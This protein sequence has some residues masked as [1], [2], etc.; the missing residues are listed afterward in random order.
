MLIRALMQTC[1]SNSC[2]IWRQ[3]N[4]PA[5]WAFSSLLHRPRSPLGV[6]SSRVRVMQTP[7]LPVYGRSPPVRLLVQPAPQLQTAGNLRG[8]IIRS[9]ASRDVLHEYEVSLRM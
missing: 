4:A 1:S 7:F 3:S 8:R 5:Y 2:P 9:A 6:H